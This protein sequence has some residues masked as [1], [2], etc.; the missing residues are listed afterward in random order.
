MESYVNSGVLY[1]RQELEEELHTWSQMDNQNA[2]GMTEPAAV[3]AW[4]KYEAVTAALSQELC[5]QLRLVLEPTQ[6]SKLR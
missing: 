4:Q 5:E 6:A 1:F 3:E 2:V